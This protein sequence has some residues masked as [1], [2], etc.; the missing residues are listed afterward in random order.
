MEA[1]EFQIEILRFFKK[2]LCIHAEV[3]IKTL[4]NVYNPNPSLWI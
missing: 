2:E 3:C 1:H 4:S